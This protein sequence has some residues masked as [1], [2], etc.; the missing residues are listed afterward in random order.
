MQIN[1]NN[2]TSLSNM[3]LKKIKEENN[4]EKHSFQKRRLQANPSLLKSSG[5]MLFVR[6]AEEE[7]RL[8]DIDSMMRGTFH[9]VF[10]DGNIAIKIYSRDRSKTNMTAAEIDEFRK[11]ELI[12]IICRI[13]GYGVGLFNAELVDKLYERFVQF[14]AEHGCNFDEAD[15][16]PEAERV[17]HDNSFDARDAFLE[18]KSN[19]LK[20]L[21]SE[22]LYS[23]IFAT[24]DKIQH[25]ISI[26]QTETKDVDESTT[27]L[28]TKLLAEFFEEKGL[29]I[30]C[31]GLLDSFIEAAQKIN[32]QVKP[33]I[34]VL[35][36]EELSQI[37]PSDHQRTREG[38]FYNV[39]GG[40]EG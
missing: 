12:Q 8:D 16:A 20:L 5:S 13:T 22:Y 29:E 10:D 17:R 25:G 33:D 19:W 11:F 14:S 7:I 18:A 23:A 40:S 36:E 15:D 28:A 6:C 2:L 31:R 34:P 32:Y 27:Q 24:M 26:T 21:L 38:M 3:A 39:V 9:V 30:V 4:L 1:A 35:S 37:E